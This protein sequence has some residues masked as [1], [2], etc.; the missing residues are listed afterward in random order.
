M[1]KHVNDYEP[2]LGSAAAVGLVITGS[3]KYWCQAVVWFKNGRLLQSHRM[4]F[5]SLN[6]RATEHQDPQLQQL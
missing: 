1:L 6:T 5:P 2:P 4:R 3:I